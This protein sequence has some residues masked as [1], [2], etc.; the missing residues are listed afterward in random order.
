MKKCPSCNREVKDGSK[1]CPYCGVPLT[2]V[3]P[4]CGA[5]VARG[6][7]CAE[8]G[9]MLIVEENPDQKKLE[10]NED[11]HESVMP[12]E[13]A[14]VEEIRS[15]VGKEHIPAHSSS[16]GEESPSTEMKDIDN[17]RISFASHK[18]AVITW[19]I[20]SGL[21]IFSIAISPVAFWIMLFALFVLLV[22]G[23][24]YFKGEKF[25]EIKK[26]ISMYIQDCNSLNSHIEDLKSTY[27]DV[28]RI[29]FGEAKFKNV[30]RYN[31]KKRNLSNVKYAPFI[32]DCSRSVCD[33]ARKQPF[34]YICKY[35]NIAVDEKNLNQFETVLNNFSAA[36][37]GKTLLANKKNII[38][39]NINNKVPWLIKR[40]FPTKLEKE[41]GFD[42]FKFDELYFPTYSFRYISA[43]GNSGTQYD[44][45]MDL[46]MLERFIG[47]LS[48]SIKNKKS[49]L[50]Q[51]KLMTPKLR[52]QIKERDN[53]TCCQCGNSVNVEPNLLLEIDH[54]IPVSKGGLTIENN[55]QTLCWKCNRSKGAKLV[56]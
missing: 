21:C 42:E 31:Y 26:Q 15:N 7:F 56:S 44:V 13:D 46:E 23:F 53:Y 25:A 30:S 8:C 28:K 33:N 45:V 34:K 52:T 24:L 16:L 19:W 20:L 1:F 54:I 6:K 55:L 32:Y 12:D 50:G 17:V 14:T 3:C 48:D 43:G 18:A 27:A 37:E 9:K 35:F 47:F 4:H 36:E 29:D 38:L 49:A 39:K 11:D 40:L 51:R 5:S 2:I 22:Y 10:A 41:L